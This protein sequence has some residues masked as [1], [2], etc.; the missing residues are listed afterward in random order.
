MSVAPRFVFANLLL[1]AALGGATYAG[2]L[3]WQRVGTLQATLDEVLGEVTRM[4][5]EQSA[6]AKGPRALLEKLRTYAPMLS[7]AR[8][9]EPDF[10]NARKE[11][12]DILRAF[13]SLG[14]DAREPVLARLAQVS[15]QKDYDECR[16]LL[17]ALLRI[18][19]AVGKERLVEVLRG[20][21][22]P[23]PQMR[24]YAASKLTE[25]DRPLAQVE[26]RRIVTSESN[27]GVNPDRSAQNAP[28]P[29]PA[30]LATSGFHNFIIHYARTEDPKL[31]ETLLMVMQRAEHDRMTVQE[32]VK[33]LG[34]DRYQPAA[35]TLE[36]L[37]RSPPLQQDDP[38]FLNVVLEAL[39][40]IQDK[41]ARPFL[42]AELA[43]A[44]H[45][46]VA[47]K[48]QSLLDKTR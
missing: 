36:K 44:T 18:D 24:W 17:D 31:D 29:D 14:E 1:L 46:V 6:G 34:E 16:F 13:G 33:Q 37:Y 7:N 8:V 45:E 25:I 26:L 38:L 30:A 2:T 19:P 47:K 41:S 3:L 11:M 32:C 22:L 40:E 21:L 20:R 23:S 15:P 39:V 42:E 9:T 28:V 48:I 12:M 35:P 4:R 43:K 27:R 10:Q 5:I